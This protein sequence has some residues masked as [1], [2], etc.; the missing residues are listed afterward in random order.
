MSDINIEISKE[1]LDSLE[2]KYK[3]TI[4]QATFLIE[5]SKGAL[6][7]IAQLRSIKNEPKES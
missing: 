5:Q 7:L 1:K 2:N 3:E 6:A 4:K